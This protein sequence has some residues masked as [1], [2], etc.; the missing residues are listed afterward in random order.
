MNKKLPTPEEYL[1]SLLRAD[2]EILWTGRI[3]APYCRH[4]HPWRSSLILSACAIVVFGTLAFFFYALS[5]RIP[6]LWHALL[7]PE[8]SI[9]YGLAV[10]LG[11]LI[12]LAL[13]FFA[14]VAVLMIQL[15]GNGF[16]G[17]IFHRTDQNQTRYTLTNRRII[18][19]RLSR[20]NLKVNY[21]RDY[22]H[23]AK[24][25]HVRIDVAPHDNTPHATFC[26]R[27][28]Q[29][30]LIGLSKSDEAALTHA[31]NPRHIPVIRAHS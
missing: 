7:Q 15:F 14:L 2:E 25:R 20:F 17:L 5:C 21:E 19:T 22:C 16:C 28:N 29:L 6:G 12:P 13:V 3:G 4:R 18:R 26:Y 11:I 31:L 8:W 27:K 23:L 1:Q 10:L 30:V 24:L 9:N